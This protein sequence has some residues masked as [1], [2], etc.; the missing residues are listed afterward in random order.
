MT[1]AFSQLNSDGPKSQ[2]RLKAIDRSRIWLSQLSM[3]LLN[4]Q[5]QQIWL[6]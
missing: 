4:V 1:I 5:A 3:W 6:D 2:S